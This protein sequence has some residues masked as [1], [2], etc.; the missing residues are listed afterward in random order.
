MLMSIPKPNAQRLR[1][2][3]AEY[4]LRAEDVAQMLGREKSTVYVWLTKNNPRD[5]P[6]DT[7]K[8]FEFICLVR[9]K[10]R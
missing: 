7:I 6:D 2:L 5:V 4:H 8:L 1:Q 10:Q 9:S 3:M